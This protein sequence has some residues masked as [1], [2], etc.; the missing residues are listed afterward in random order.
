MT[1]QKIE[2]EF[3]LSVQ[4]PQMAKQPNQPNRNDVDH[5]D[6]RCFRPGRQGDVRSVR[7]PGCQGL[8]TKRVAWEAARGLVRSSRARQ[9]CAKAQTEKSPKKDKKAKEKKPRAKTD[10]LL[11]AD[12]ARDQ[13]REEMLAGLRRVKADWQ[14]CGLQDCRPLVEQR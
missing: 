7:G 14:G 1:F 8:G 2:T 13:V 11:F 10:C 9:S 5:H 12:H 3:L 4:V 6:A